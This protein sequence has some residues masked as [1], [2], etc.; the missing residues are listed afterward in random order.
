MKDGYPKKRRLIS[1]D[2]NL[3]RNQGTHSLEISYS[4]TYPVFLNPAMDKRYFVRQWFIIIIFR[5]RTLYFKVHPVDAYFYLFHRQS[6]MLAVKSESIITGRKVCIDG[7]ADS[8][9]NGPSD[10]SC[11]PQ[12]V[13]TAGIAWFQAII[14]RWRNFKIGVPWRSVWI[15]KKPSIFQL[16]RPKD[17][18]ISHQDSR[19]VSSTRLLERHPKHCGQNL[20]D[21][22]DGV[23]LYFTIQMESSYQDP[24]KINT[25]DAAIKIENPRLPPSNHIET[26]KWKR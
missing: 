22:Q 12:K 7:Q 10:P 18:H 23:F 5:S 15:L 17:K 21:T 20:L 13:K 24:L 25:G 19:N 11:S 2:R 3:S 8:D 16:K 14:N 4:E 9:S 1:P 26:L 6:E